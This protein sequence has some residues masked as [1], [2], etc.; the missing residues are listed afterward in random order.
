VITRESADEAWAAERELR[1]ELGRTLSPRQRVTAW[2]RYHRNRPP[3]HVAG[4]ASWADAARARETQR[5]S[6]RRRRGTHRRH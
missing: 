4:P 2:L 5:R 1:R 6:R 3:V